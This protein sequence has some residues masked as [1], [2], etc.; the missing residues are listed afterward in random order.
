MVAELTPQTPVYRFVEE[1]AHRADLLEELGLDFCCGGQKPLEDACREKGLD[2]QEVF[3]RLM[4]APAGQA[5][6]DT[7]ED[8]QNSTPSEMV[9]H[10]EKTHH[11]YL[12]AAMPH[13]QQLIEKVVAAHGQNHPELKEV[14]ALFQELV[15]DL[16]PHMMKEERVL[17]PMI[18]KLDANLETGEFHCGSI[19]NPIRVMLMEHDR[20][21]I[22]LEK[23]KTATGN[24]N[25]PEDACGS[26][27]LLM[28]ELKQFALDTHLHIHKENNLLF[29]AVLEACEEAPM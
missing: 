3:T 5:P 24:F 2:V 29:P 6:T 21:G 18:R 13:I 22:L 15:D 14:E 26:Y 4:A 28:K 16:G 19:R 10:I 7:P 25:P 17:F 27:R 12:K 11:V 23:I 8:F 20:A 9:D 1:G